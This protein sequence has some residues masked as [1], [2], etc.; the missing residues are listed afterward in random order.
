MSTRH[1]IKFEDASHT[2]STTLDGG[3]GVPTAATCTLKDTDG[4]YLLNGTIT[5]VTDATGGVCTFAYTGHAVAKGDVVTVAGTTSYN[6]AQT[7]IA[8]A[9]GT[10]NA[11]ETYVAT[12]TGTYEITAATATMMTA[13]TLSAAASAG[14]DTITLTAVTS[15]VEGSTLR[16]AASAD[17][18]HEDV[19]VAAVGAAE[20]ILTDYLAYKHTTATAVSGRFLSYAIDASQA[21]FTSGLDFSVIWD[22]TD[23]DDPAWREEGEILKREVAFGGLE[24]TFKARCQHYYLGIPANEFNTYQDAAFAYLRNHVNRV[25]GQDIDKLVNPDSIEDVL[26]KKIMFDVAWAG[27]D[28][29]QSERVAT[30]MLFDDAWIGFL[31]ANDWID[32]N[33][34][35]IKTDSETQPKLRPLPRRRLF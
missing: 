30:K 32:S 17:G 2:L 25:S 34:D 7:V 20:V 33:Q 13:T 5:G 27:G 14:E 18:P 15:I 24:A 22:L 6:A 4:A 29:W 11:T 8:V 35:D 16:I 9:A 21:D 19:V 28:E 23:T 12:E 26:V 3:L 1:H 10:F 31:K